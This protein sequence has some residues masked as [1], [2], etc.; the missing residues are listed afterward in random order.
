MAGRRTSIS[1][2]SPINN[3]PQPRFICRR[4]RPC[5]P[6]SNRKLGLLR[7]DNE[8]TFVTHTSATDVFDPEDHNK[9]VDSPTAA[10]SVLVIDPS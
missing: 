7:I 4:L 1:A 3:A 8:V 2:A 10:T 6:Q 9:V 5:S